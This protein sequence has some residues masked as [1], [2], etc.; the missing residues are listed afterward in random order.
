MY[1]KILNRRLRANPAAGGSPLWRFFLPPPTQQ[2]IIIYK[3]GD[4]W[5][6]MTF[7]ED[8]IASPEVYQ[9]IPGGHDY[10]CQVGSFEY[11]AL[12]AQGYDFERVY[13]MHDYRDEYTEEYA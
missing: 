5:E 12:V 8:E 6:R 9:Y 7:S 3:N 13:E 2:S 11:D 4:V 1:E 10:R